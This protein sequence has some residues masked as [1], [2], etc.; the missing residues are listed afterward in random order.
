MLAGACAC[1]ALFQNFFVGKAVCAVRK[2]NDAAA[3][4]TVLFERVLHDDVAGM[5]IASHGGDTRFK[6]EFR[7]VGHQKRC[8]AALLRMICR[9][10]AVHDAVD[11]VFCLPR[12]L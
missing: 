8:R 10:N 5:R 4:V 7:A 11:F 12:A 9:H 1:C 2:V 3:N 6:R